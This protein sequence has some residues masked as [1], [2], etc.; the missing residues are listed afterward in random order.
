MA[1]KTQTS[2]TRSSD[3][4]SNI[5]MLPNSKLLM[6]YLLPYCA[7]VVIATLFGHMAPEWNY[8][9]RIFIVSIA[10]GWAWRWYVPLRGPK[11]YV[12]SIFTGVIFGLV[13]TVLWVVCLFPF[14]KPE[15]QPWGGFPFLARLTASTLLVPIFEE[16]LMRVYIF[17]LA[18]QWDIERRN[19]QNHP[20]DIV[21]YKK[22]LNDFKPGEWSYFAIIF[23]TIAFALGHQMVEWPAAIIYGML[24]AILWIIRKDIIS[25]VVAH[26]T[27]NFALAIYIYM[28]GSWE[29]W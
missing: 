13:G 12:A 10:L 14:L 1:D 11:N 20:F 22:S 29:L 19:H 23:S 7:Y 2:S 16:L 9:L 26:G 28:T 25:C 18:Y 21:F 15:T 6:P 24:M 4:G 17:R 3:T 8:L 27:T 5:S